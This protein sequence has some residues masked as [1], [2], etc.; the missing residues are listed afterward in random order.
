MDRIRCDSKAR[1]SSP[2]SAGKPREEGGYRTRR[3]LL[4]YAGAV[5][6]VESLPLAGNRR[7]KAK[8]RRWSYDISFPGVWWRSLRR[9]QES[10]IPKDTVLVNVKAA[11]RRASNLRRLCVRE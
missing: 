11:L 8:G 1:P 9:P 10:T 5:A 4:S 6:G 7:Q 3:K 2:A